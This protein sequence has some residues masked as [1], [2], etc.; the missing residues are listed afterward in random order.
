MEFAL[1]APFLFVLHL[2]AGELVQV[3]QVQRRIAHM[4]SAM[5]DITSQSRALTDAEIADILQAGRVMILPFPETSLGQ[6]ISSIS[7]NAAGVVTTDWTLNSSYP[8]GSPPSVPAGFLR[9]NESVIVADVVYDYRPAFGL[10]LPTTLRFE[11]HA[12]LRPRLADK[13]TRR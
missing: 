11:R 12:Y 13:V 6:R 4:A 3:F 2:A 5:A 10:Y 7:A 9:A 8:A 1:L